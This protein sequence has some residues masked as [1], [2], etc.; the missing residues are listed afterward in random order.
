MLDAC[1]SFKNYET[2]I[3]FYLDKIPAD[4]RVPPVMCRYAGLL[5]SSGKRDEAVQ[6]YR[7][8]LKEPS[9]YGDELFVQEVAASA[10]KKLGDKAALEIFKVEPA[11]EKLKRPNQHIVS[12]M[13]Y[14]S[15]FRTEAVAVLDSLLSTSED[16]EEKASLLTRKGVIREEE[17]NYEAA[18]QC[19][20]EAVKYNPKSYVVLNNLAFVLSDKLGKSADAVPY[21]ERAAQLSGQPAVI[22]TL[23]WCRVQLGQYS[24]AIGDLSKAL[25]LDPQ[26]LPA[27]AHRAEAFRRSERFQDAIQA[28]EAAL[29]IIGATVN[30]E[31]ISYRP[32]IETGLQKC[33][34]KDKSP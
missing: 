26:F 20:E 28:Y 5:A 15:G 17:K 4:R 22:D 2:G 16:D 29:K 19:Y 1:D 31:Y 33:Q 23:G 27:H 6:V 10:S 24:Q 34:D 9:A 11:D 7:E 12:F 25:M 13:L 21:A 8:A 18:K 3:R 32:M 14:N 30:P